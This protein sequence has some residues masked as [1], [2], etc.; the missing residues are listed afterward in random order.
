MTLFEIIAVL[1]IVGI[2]VA[3]CLPNFTQ[4][5]EQALAA[6]ARNNLLAIYSAQQNYYNNQTPPAY[7]LAAAGACDTLADINTN[8]SL[9]IQD[10]GSY[11]YACGVD[12]NGSAFACTATRNNAIP[13]TANVITVTDTPIK[14]N[15]GNPTCTNASSCA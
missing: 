10:D 8:L 9:S 2:A 4:P 5:N 6:N 14:L 15:A 13:S 3:I 12:P 7:C 1:I 11:A